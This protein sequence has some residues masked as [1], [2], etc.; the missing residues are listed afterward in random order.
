MTKVM[1]V[2][3]GNI[4]RSPLAEAIFKHKVKTRGLDGVLAADS[5]GTSD[6]HIGQPPD[7]RT[8]R[9]A[10]KNGITITHRGQQLSLKH[11]DEYDYVFAMD[12]RNHES[13]KRLANGR[14]TRARIDLIRSFDPLGPGEEVPDPYFGGERGFQE[15][16]EMLDRSIDKLIDY[17]VDGNG[18]RSRPQ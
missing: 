18:D 13:T 12:F 8:M 4:C 1:F 10:L 14:N 15:V 6:Y 2:C 9:N 11:L 3:L 5:A 16:F 17:L 7:D